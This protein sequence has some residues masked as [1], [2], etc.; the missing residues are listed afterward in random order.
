MIKKLRI[1]FICLIMVSL[2]L[3]L[4]IIIGSVNLLNYQRVVQNAD[5]ILSLLAE[6]DGHFP[7]TSAKSKKEK[8]SLMSPEMPYES[9]FFSVRT[10]STGEVTSTDTRKIAAIDSETAIE[11][12]KSVQSRK[13][14]CGFLGNYRYCIQESDDETLIIFL[15]C[16]RSLTTFRT[17]LL[18]SCTISL[19]GLFSVLLLVFLFS[20]RIVKP[21]IESYEKQKRFI[22]DAGHEIKTPLAIIDAD[23]DVLELDFGENEW[24]ADIQKQTRRLNELTSSL[25]CLARMEEDP[26]RFQMIEFPFSDM[27]AET[28]QSFQALAKA[29]DMV[30]STRICPMLCLRGDEKA[31]R[32]LITILLDNALK[33][34]RTGSE[35]SL[36]LEKL[37]LGIRLT[38]TNTPTSCL[39]PDSLKHLFDRF[40]RTDA[41]RNSQNGGYGIGLSIAH[42]IVAAHR[43]KITASSADAHSLTITVLLY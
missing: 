30:L 2:L 26:E 1:K 24:I 43:G 15:D 37:S 7:K 42:A 20:R 33:Y 35:I 17:F 28:A 40:Y 10:D 41:S 39:S 11:Y 25:I 14:S 16:G 27:V 23:T 8:K 4:T 36:S 9:R 38:V 22:T 34:S 3:V 32:Q 29:R 31:L 18:T 13:D 12:A 21:V 19:A 5:S 6:N